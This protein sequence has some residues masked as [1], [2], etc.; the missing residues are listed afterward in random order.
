MADG[1]RVSFS[2]SVLTDHTRLASSA[3]RNLLGLELLRISLEGAS[4]LELSSLR[5]VVVLVTLATGRVRSVIASTHGSVA[6]VSGSACLSDKSSST[7]VRSC[8]GVA[9]GIV[10]ISEGSSRTVELPCVTTR[11]LRSSDTFLALS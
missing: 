3:V 1:T 6:R 11:A 8:A 4:L 5:T 9:I 7:V 10:S 2:V